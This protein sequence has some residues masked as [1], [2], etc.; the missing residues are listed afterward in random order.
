MKVEER[1]KKNRCSFKAVYF[2][3]NIF[4]KDIIMLKKTEMNTKDIGEW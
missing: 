3:Y 4:K 1:I 2:G